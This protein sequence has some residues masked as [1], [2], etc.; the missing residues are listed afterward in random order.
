MLFDVG[1]GGVGGG[2]LLCSMGLKA[3]VPEFC[4]CDVFGAC[5][6]SASA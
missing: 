3:L 2:C 1:A 4:V 6:E 5:L